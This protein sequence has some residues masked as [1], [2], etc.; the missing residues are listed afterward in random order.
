MGTSFCEVLY[1][2]CRPV[3]RKVDPHFSSPDPNNILYN[4]IEMFGPPDN[5]FQIN[6]V[7]IFGVP[8][9][10][11]ILWTPLKYFIPL[12]FVFST[13]CKGGLFISPQI[14]DSPTT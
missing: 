5:L 7:E 3:T 2:S 14:F 8:G 12:E 11:L 10:K 1:K 13:L 4:Y 6:F 9:T